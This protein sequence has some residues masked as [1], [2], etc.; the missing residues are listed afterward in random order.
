M[1]KKRPPSPCD[2]GVWAS[3]VPQLCGHKDHKKSDRRIPGANHEVG[4]NQLHEFVLGGMRNIPH[5][6]HRKCGDECCQNGVHG[7][8]LFSLKS[9]KNI[10]LFYIKVK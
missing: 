5:T 1:N 9:N 8:L 4:R 6:H 10:T 7:L 3:G 2:G